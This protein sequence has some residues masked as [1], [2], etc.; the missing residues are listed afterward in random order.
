MKQTAV[1]MLLATLSLSACVS[2][3]RGPDAFCAASA[4][5]Y[6]DAADVLTKGTLLAVLK[7]NERGAE[8]CGWGA[9]Q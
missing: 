4:P 8:L 2:A 9:A 3:G 6:L 7:H 5:I 1:W